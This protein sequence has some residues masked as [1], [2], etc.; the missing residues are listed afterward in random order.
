MQL[1]EDIQRA[2]GMPASA[3]STSTTPPHPVILIGL[4]GHGTRLVRLAVS[5]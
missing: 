2:R 1:A 4:P 3:N 5:T